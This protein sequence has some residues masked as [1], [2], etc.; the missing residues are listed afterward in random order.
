METSEL[1][2]RVRRI[3]IKTR[4]LT[5]NIFAGEYHSAYK[6][7]GKSIDKLIKNQTGYDILDYN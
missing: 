1:L 6:G 5:N 2:S 4:A 3:E 7:H